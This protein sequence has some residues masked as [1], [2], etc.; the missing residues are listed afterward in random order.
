MKFP[1]YFLSALAALILSTSCGCDDDDAPDPCAGGIA[2]P[3]TIEFRED[4]GTPTPDTAIS[5]RTITFVAP[6]APYSASSYRWRIGRD[7][8]EQTG[9]QVSLFFQKDEQGPLLIEL[10]ATRPARPACDPT[11]DGIDTLR[12]TLYL[13]PYADLPLAPIYGR[14]HGANLDA[15]ADTFTVEVLRAPCRPSPDVEDCSYVRNLGRGCQSPYFD[16]RPNWRGVF[17]NYGGNDYGCLSENGKGY[18]T[19]R[20]EIRF[21][22]EHFVS[23]TGFALVKRVF[24]GRRVR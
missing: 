24:V 22:Y 10:I 21:E 17:F 4:T 13:R 18:L 23:A 15:P 12:R 9:R 19:S 7:P 14:F 6:G 1:T 3:P 16:A 2:T 20:D 8:R 11:D 5:G